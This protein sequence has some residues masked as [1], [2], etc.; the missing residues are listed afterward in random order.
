MTSTEG[1]ATGDARSSIRGRAP[2]RSCRS[3]TAPTAGSTASTTATFAV[4]GGRDRSPTSTCASTSCATPSSATCRS[5]SIHDGVTAVLARPTST[6][7][8]YGGDDI[9][10]AVFDSDARAAAA[11]R[12]PGTDHRSRPDAAGELADAF[13][14]QPAAA[15]GRC[16]SPTTAAATPASCAAGASTP[17]RCRAGGSRSRPPRPATPSGVG[18]DGGDADGAVTPNG[19]ATGLRFSYGTTTAYGTSTATQDVGAGDA[20]RPGTAALAG[21]AP[22]TT[23]H[24]RVEAI[25]EGGAV[26]V[27]GADRT[28]THR[29]AAAVRLRPPPPPLRL[30]PAAASASAAAT[31]PPT[32]ARRVIG[33][34]HG[35]SSARRPSAAQAAVVPVHA[36]RG[37]VREAHAHPAREGRA[38]G[39]ALRQA[40]EDE[41]GHAL[42]ASGPG[43]HDDAGVRRRP[44]RTPHARRDGPEKGKYVA[45]LV[46]TDRRRSSRRRRS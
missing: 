36:Q 18:T 35:A 43:E 24:Y 2:A 1:D 25:R 12:R 39:Q 3:P 37:G 46:A 34:R 19:R 7:A 20:R 17:R 44:A 14:G 31:S 5:R 9:L 45:T 21:L 8:D 13:D 33:N 38:Q 42:H 4:A 27:A 11:A 41:Q 32:D 16:G 22:A 29:A 28:F 26:A 23:Y 40:D 6:A 30:R 15:P 10:D